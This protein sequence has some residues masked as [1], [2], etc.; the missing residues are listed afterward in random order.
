M[1]KNST[2]LR[3]F[4]Q[5][6]SYNPKYFPLFFLHT[7]CKNISFFYSLWMTAEIINGLYEGREKGELYFLVAAALAGILLPWKFWRT[8]RRRPFTARPRD[9]TMTNWKTPISAG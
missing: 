9:L 2:T 3:A 4:R 1:K 5:Y 6:N 8:M 7:I